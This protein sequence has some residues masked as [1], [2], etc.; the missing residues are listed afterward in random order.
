MKVPIKFIYKKRQFSSTGIT[1]FERE[2]FEASRIYKTLQDVD[3]ETRHY[4]LS[5]LTGDRIRLFGYEKVSKYLSYKNQIKLLLVSFIGS[6]IFNDTPVLLDFIPLCQNI[7]KRYEAVNDYFNNLSMKR[8]WKA[9]QNPGSMFTNR[10][11]IVLGKDVDH[12][13]VTVSFKD[14]MDI[15]R[16]LDTM[17]KIDDVNELREY[18]HKCLLELKAYPFNTEDYEESL[19]DIFHEKFVKI[20]DDMLDQAKNRLAFIRDFSEL[21]NLVTHLGD[22]LTEIGISE[23]QR[24]RLFDLYNLRKEELKKEKLDEIENVLKK[25]GNI[26]ELDNYW[27]VLKLYLKNNRQFFGKE[28]ETLVAKRL[29]EEEKRL[30][31][32]PV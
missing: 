3:R 6:D 5:K 22:E 14:S 9:R 31:K 2:L 4:F 12:N 25:I 23:E 24:H 30:Q 19:S 15:S 20:T 10:E 26:A 1:T 8:I 27:N 7:E 17:E 18:Y 29:D 13:V 28:F 11:G 16:R 21:H 32:D